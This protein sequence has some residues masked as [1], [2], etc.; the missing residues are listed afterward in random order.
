MRVF[1]RVAPAGFSCVVSAGVFRA[2][3]LR[4][5]R[6]AARSRRVALD[7]WQTTLG[8]PSAP[9]RNYLLGRAQLLDKLLIHQ[10][11]GSQSPDR[12]EAEN[13]PALAA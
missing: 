12:Y 2:E 4:N 9:Q 10:T 1:Q 5:G 7:V 13:A 8:K 3:A 11:V 6:L